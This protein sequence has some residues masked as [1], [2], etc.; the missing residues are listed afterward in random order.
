MSL[1]HFILGALADRPMT[2]YDL[3]KSFQ[4]SINHFWSTDQSQIYRA[5]QALK[6]GGFVR[7]ELRVQHDFPN[8]KVYYI[9]AAG[10][11]KLRRWLR[12]PLDDQEA[13]VRQGWLGQLFFGSHVESRRTIEVMEAYLR[14]EEETI[15]HLISIRD[16]V[17]GE[18]RGEQADRGAA[19]RLATLEYGITMRRAGAEWL[20]QLV[21]ELKEEK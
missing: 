11:E 8:K 17:L 5:L 10:E 15:E 12:T 9:T 14:E 6:K 20:Y 4:N 7:D 21:R 13:P 1:Q 3:N 2:G 16:D 19:L 18:A